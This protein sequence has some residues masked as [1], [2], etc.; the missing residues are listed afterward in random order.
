M[1][2]LAAFACVNQI[3]SRLAFDAATL[4]KAVEQMSALWTAK[5]E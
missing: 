5:R 3:C 2:H 1:R 4:A